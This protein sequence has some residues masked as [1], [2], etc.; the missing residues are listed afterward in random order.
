MFPI[1]L[2]SW[3]LFDTVLN[4][5][6]ELLSRI[7]NFVLSPR[8][9]CSSVKPTQRWQLPFIYFFVSVTRELCVYAVMYYITSCTLS[10]LVLGKLQL[11]DG[12]TRQEQLI[13]KSVA[14]EIYMLNT[15]SAE[16]EHIIALLPASAHISISNLKYSPKS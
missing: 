14:I 12:K 8:F 4:F 10:S 13:N 11:H 2:S 3:K 16:M 9:T 5:T 1:N 6:L 15:F 7:I